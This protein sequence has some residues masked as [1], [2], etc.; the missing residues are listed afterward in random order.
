MISL[1]RFGFFSYEGPEIEDE[2]SYERLPPL[3]MDVL[4]RVNGFI[5]YRGGFHLRGACL[6]PSWHALHTVWDGD[7]SLHRAYPGVWPTDVP[8]AQDALGD[9]FL[10]RDGQVLRLWAETGELED[11]GRDLAAFLVGLQTDPYELLD[12]QPLLLFEQEGG[13]L[14]PGQL[15]H[16][17]PPFSLQGDDFEG[18]VK[19]SAEDAE[20]RL[21]S[22]ALL[23]Q[24]TTKLD[25]L[26]GDPVDLL[27]LARVQRVKGAR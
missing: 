8:F 27:T 4:M 2:A 10:L 9:Q 16:A 25:P 20:D 21:Y 11:L 13:K 19:L 5:A 6:T 3:L 17:D 24:E 22:L 15:L 1:Q 26:G 14:R 23:A 7:L 18:E 12:V